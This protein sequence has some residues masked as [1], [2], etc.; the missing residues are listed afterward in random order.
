MLALDE[1]NAPI[2]RVSGPVWHPLPQTSGAAE[3]VAAAVAHEIA[4]SRSKLHTDSELVVGLFAKPDLPADAL[5]SGVLKHARGQVCA[6]N[7]KEIIWVKGHVEPES[8][9]GLERRHAIGNKAADAGADVGRLAHPP[10]FT[11]SLQAAL[12]TQIKHAGLVLSTIAEVWKEFPPQ[13]ERGPRAPLAARASAA[14]SDPHTWSSL[15]PGLGWRCNTCWCCAATEH[16]KAQRVLRGCKPLSLAKALQEDVS[17]HARS[18]RLTAARCEDGTALVICLACGGWG[19]IRARLL[20]KPCRG[21][22]G[23]GRG[24]SEAV[25]RVGLGLHP[26][27]SYKT[28]LAETVGTGQLAELFPVSAVPAVPVQGQSGSGDADN[29]QQQRRR[30]KALARLSEQAGVKRIKRQQGSPAQPAADGC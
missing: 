17:Q 1:H 2:A 12:D 24:G 16:A 23:A 28:R 13:L 14:R 29:H 6:S 11:A 9:V 3:V 5:Y 21:A 26:H 4:E 18:H 15:G 7:V 19:S 8:V 25:R 22:K 27:T 10:P 30:L 20:A